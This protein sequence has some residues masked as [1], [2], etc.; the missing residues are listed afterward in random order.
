MKKAKKRVKEKTMEIHV[1]GTRGANIDS[2]QITSNPI[3]SGHYYSLSDIRTTTNLVA[4]KPLAPKSEFLGAIQLGVT[5]GTVLFF[6]IL[7]WEAVI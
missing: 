7:F 3:W 4:K 6:T 2:S 1:E 5:L